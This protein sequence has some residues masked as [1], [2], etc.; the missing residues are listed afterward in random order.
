MVHQKQGV[1]TEVRQFKSSHLNGDA[2]GNHQFNGTISFRNHREL[3]PHCIRDKVGQCGICNG[4]VV[5]GQVR[6]FDWLQITTKR[7][8][9][10]RLPVNRSL[11]CGRFQEGNGGETNWIPVNIGLPHAPAVRSCTQS[12][13][14][15][16]AGSGIQFQFGH[17]NC[18]RETIGEIFPGRVQVAPVVHPHIGAGIQASRTGGIIG[19]GVDGQ[20]RQ[21]SFKLSPIPSH[22]RRLPDFV[23]EGDVNGAVFTCRCL[24]GA[25]GLRTERE[26]IR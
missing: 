1:R 19:Q 6:H 24:D 9:D 5:R 15:I 10:L 20:R 18:G 26:V 21:I 4:D 3:I 23:I 16:G 25:H 8:L 13:R 14:V 11:P 22:V 17:P 7:K 2:V 12:L